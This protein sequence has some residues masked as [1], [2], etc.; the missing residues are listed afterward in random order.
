[1]TYFIS[2]ASILAS[3]TFI[4]ILSQELGLENTF[5]TLVVALYSFFVFLGS[6]IGGRAS[7]RFN[8][9]IV[10]LIGLFTSTITFS[11]VFFAQDDISLLIFRIAAGFSA[12]LAPP[13]MIALAYEQR[14]KMGI[15]SAFGALGWG[16]GTIVA[17]WVALFQKI[18]L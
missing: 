11:G 10:I 1:M 7:D 12:G 6:A 18:H 17:G 5:I 14:H 15:F 2:S 4:P 16:F 13:A 9:K 3:I 8:R